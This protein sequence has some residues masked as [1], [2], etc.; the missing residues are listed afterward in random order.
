MYPSIFPPGSIKCPSCG[1]STH[2]SYWNDG[3]SASK[4]PRL[5]HDMD[6]VV[7]LVSAVYRCENGHKLLAHD[8]SILKCFPLKSMIPFILLSRTGFTRQFVNACTSLCRR[9]LNFYNIETMI[10]ERRWLM[11]AGQLDML[12]IHKTMIG[13]CT[14]EGDFWISPVSKCPSND[15]ILKCFLSG[16]LQDEYLYLQEMTAIS[17]GKSI[18]FDH[19]FKVAANIGFLREDGTWLEVH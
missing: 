6:N 1:S 18:S 11:Y 4:Q 2:Q 7:L 13:Q 12:N 3:S 17:V 9:G 8:D 14:G 15:I 16:F 10:I 5:I 19:T